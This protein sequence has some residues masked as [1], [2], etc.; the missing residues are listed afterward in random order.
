[1]EST[2]KSLT[3]HFFDRSLP[4]IGTQMRVSQRRGIR[5]VPGKLLDLEQRHSRGDRREQ[6]VWRKS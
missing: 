2:T 3:Q 4:V 5:F 6:N 1:M